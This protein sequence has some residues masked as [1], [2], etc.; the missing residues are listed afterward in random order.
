MVRDPVALEAAL[1]AA[2]DVDQ[3]AVRIS[4][5]ESHSVQ[6]C[7]CGVAEALAGPQAMIAT[8]R[9]A[10]MPAR[11]LLATSFGCPLEGAVPVARVVELA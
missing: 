8:A 4:A 9:G 3:I 7:G 5:S 10:W 11:A 6:A 2:H 1:D